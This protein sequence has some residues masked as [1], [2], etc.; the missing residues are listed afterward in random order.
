MFFKRGKMPYGTYKVEGPQAQ[1][2]KKSEFVH[3]H[4]LRVN[5]TVPRR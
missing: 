1:A 2:R 4:D 5:T 3:G